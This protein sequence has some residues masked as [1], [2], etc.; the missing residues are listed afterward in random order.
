M[1]GEAW[2]FADVREE[3]VATE[4]LVSVGD[5][6]SSAAGCMHIWVMGLL[7]SFGILWPSG[8]GRLLGNE[9]KAIMMK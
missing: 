3:A 5:G 6:C 7:G 4:R 2:E 9:V 1:V 8:Y